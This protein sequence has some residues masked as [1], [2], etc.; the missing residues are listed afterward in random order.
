MVVKKQEVP[1]YSKCETALG[2]HF[3]NKYSCFIRPCIYIYMIY[4][5]H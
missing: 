2:C 3:Y 4:M 5:N 1:I